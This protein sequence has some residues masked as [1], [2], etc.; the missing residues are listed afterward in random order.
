V[1]P[2]LLQLRMNKPK[3]ATRNRSKSG[4]KSKQKRR[5]D[6][7]RS[8]SGNR[9]KPNIPK[10]SSKDK[11]LPSTIKGPVQSNDDLFSPKR[12]RSRDKIEKEELNDSLKSKSRDALK[13]DLS[14][15]TRTSSRDKTKAVNDNNSKDVLTE[16]ASNSGEKSKDRCSPKLTRSR[17][18]NHEPKNIL[19]KKKEVNEVSER[20]KPDNKICS[21]AKRKV[22]SSSKPSEEK[23]STVSSV[24]KKGGKSVPNILK[25]SPQKVKTNE[26]T[27]IS[28]E[29]E[30][31]IIEEL[32]ANELR[33]AKNLVEP[34]EPSYVVS[35]SRDVKNNPVLNTKSVGITKK[36]EVTLDD[37]TEMMTSTPMDIDMLAEKS[38]QILSCLT[39]L[40]APSTPLEQDVPLSSNVPGCSS[41][42]PLLEAQPVLSRSSFFVFQNKLPFGVFEE[43]LK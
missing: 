17:S 15:T 38:A 2:I 13:S 34:K 31:N 20:G 5:T 42:E 16:E 33:D 23:V 37:D 10:S 19:E 9:I 29:T 21:E 14:R 24:K 36:I 28:K 1:D 3:S 40:P 6:R 12:T 39:K 43:D 27:S 35:T 4:E 32:Q 30:P 11:P 8:P 26:P 25:K 22:N 18:G 7:S 41:S